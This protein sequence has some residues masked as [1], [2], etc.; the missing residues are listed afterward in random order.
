[1]TTNHADL[2]RRLIEAAEFM[3]QGKAV[4][5]PAL[6]RE[7]AGTLTAVERRRWEAA[8]ADFG[9]ESCRQNGR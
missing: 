9:P 8:R 5:A 4:F 6:L 1:M 7:A 2:C 3:E